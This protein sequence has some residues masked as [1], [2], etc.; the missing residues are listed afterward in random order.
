MGINIFQDK[1]KS[2]PKSSTNIVRVSMTEDEI[3]ARKES[4]PKADTSAANIAHVANRGG[5]AGE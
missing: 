4:M 5:G 2:V 3:V 1:T